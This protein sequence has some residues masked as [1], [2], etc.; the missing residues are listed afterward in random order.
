MKFVKYIILSVLLA[1]AGCKSEK[2]QVIETNDEK[3]IMGSPSDFK[4]ETYIWETWTYPNV[5]K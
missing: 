4:N 1:F 5:K 3:T 2:I